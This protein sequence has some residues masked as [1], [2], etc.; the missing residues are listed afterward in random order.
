MWLWLAL[1]CFGAAIGFARIGYWYSGS[2]ALLAMV[3]CSYLHARARSPWRRHLP[4]DH[5]GDINAQR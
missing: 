2:A 3:L 5:H 4:Q 1:S